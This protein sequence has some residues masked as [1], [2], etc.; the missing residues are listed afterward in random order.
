MA[1]QPLSLSGASI[2]IEYALADEPLDAL[3]WRTLGAVNGIE[4]VLALNPRLTADTL[5]EGTP[6][7]LPLRTAS[8]RM[9]ETV[10]LWS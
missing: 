4:D 5:A 1:Q 2:T 7:R 10:Q 3:C 8:P 6:V 9:L